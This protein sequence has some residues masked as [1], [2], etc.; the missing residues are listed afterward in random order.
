MMKIS[1]VLREPEG[2]GIAAGLASAT[3]LL[4]QINPLI[5]AAAA[6]IAAIRAARDAA[7]AANP[8][9]PEGTLPSDTELISRLLSESGLLKADAQAAQEWLKTLPQTP[10]STNP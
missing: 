6:I 10:P 9:T 1:D 2:G 3:T 8:T 7:K 5:G 4:G